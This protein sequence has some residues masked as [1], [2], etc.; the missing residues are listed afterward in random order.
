M[1]SGGLTTVLT[2]SLW[3]FFAFFE[4]VLLLTILYGSKVVRLWKYERCSN[5]PD[6]SSKLSGLSRD[7]FLE[8]SGVS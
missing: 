6:V 1:G 3:D 5:T 8:E 7:L 4:A 2:G